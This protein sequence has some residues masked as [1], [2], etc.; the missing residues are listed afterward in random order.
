MRKKLVRTATGIVGVVSMVWAMFG[1]LEPIH[2]VAE[3]WREWLLDVVPPKIQLQ[4]GDRMID[5]SR[6][7]TGEIVWAIQQ[8]QKESAADEKHSRSLAETESRIVHGQELLRQKLQSLR[9][10][11]V[12]CVE[13]REYSRDELKQEEQTLDLQLRQNRSEHRLMQDRIEVKQK[14]LATLR[15]RV[16]SKY[17]AV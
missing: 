13:G 7:E 9:P 17:S 1:S 4:I 2:L 10:S 14:H 11:E 6:G 8:L 5:A 16:W 12:W 15:H 3:N